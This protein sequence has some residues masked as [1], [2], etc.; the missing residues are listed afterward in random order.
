MENT[1]WNG[2]GKF[3]AQY[4]ECL[5]KLVP[6]SG[7]CDT[8]A[9]E[10]VRAASRL[11]YDFYNN[12]MGNNT[13]GAL[14]FLQQNSA[15]SQDVYSTIY[16]YTRGRFY[17]GNYDGDALQL[18]IEKCVNQTMGMITS[19]PHLMSVENTKDMFDL[20]DDVQ[21]FCEQCGDEVESLRCGYICQSCEELNE[22][23]DQEEEDYA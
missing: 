8:L 23:Y 2:K 22:Y 7:K 9:G 13:S 10:L 12:G 20:E 1:Y 19:N 15:I 6:D 3:Q 21:R 16:E 4:N 5:D 11:S 18:A 17:D 14:N